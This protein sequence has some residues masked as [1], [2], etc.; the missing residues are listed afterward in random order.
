[1]PTYTYIAKS[2][3]HKTLQGEIEAETQQEAINKLAQM[4]YFPI[5]VSVKGIYSDSSVVFGLRRIPHKD[6]VLFTHQLLTLIES[7]VNIINALNSVSNQMP[8]KYLRVILNEVISKIKDGKTLSASLAGYPGIFSELYTSMILS[9]EVGGKLELVLR[10]LADFLE[11]EEEFKNSLRAALVY[12]IFVFV[13]GV[14]TVVIL[15]TFVIPRL[16]TMF[17]DMGQSLPL[18]TQVLIAVSGFLRNYGW[19]IL[20][21][22]F[23]F[24]FLLQRIKRTVQGRFYWDSFKLKLALWGEII[25]KT[26]ISRLMRTLSLLLS[27]GITI[28]RSLEISRSIIANQVLRSEIQRFKEEIINGA[29]FSRSLKTSRFFPE[30]VTNIVSIGEETGSLEKSLLR[31]ANDYEKEVDRILKTLAR[32]LEPLIILIIGVVV[33]FIVLSMLL[34]IFQINLIVR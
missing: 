29:N 32:M 4:G 24:I 13:V 34:P 9:G 17:Q 15:L 7:G 14:S 21:I 6:I 19:I 11:K 30:F 12:P 5:S 20:A 1:M 22:F 28:V 27:S 16:V 10:H 8:N 2:S 25:L 26:E 33:G 31:I 18:P 3:P 23:V